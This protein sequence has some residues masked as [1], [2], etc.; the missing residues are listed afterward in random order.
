MQRQSSSLILWCLHALHS[1]YNAKGWVSLFGSQRWFLLLPLPPSLSSF[2]SL[3]LFLSQDSH[4]DHKHKK[5]KKKKKKEKKHKIKVKK[6]KVGRPLHSQ[7]FSCGYALT[8]FYVRGSYLLTLY[9]TLWFCVW[10]TSLLI[11]TYLLFKLILPKQTCSVGSNNTCSTAWLPN[12]TEKDL[13]SVWHA[14]AL[15]IHYH[16]V[17]VCVWL[18]KRDIIQM[19]NSKI[20]IEVGI[21]ILLLFFSIS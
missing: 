20:D 12:K 19:N 7:H 18:E 21:I 13:S 8:M 6:D 2:Y 11:G 1:I 14:K 5:D 4:H 9:P 3:S 16:S 10:Y 17:C 15:Y